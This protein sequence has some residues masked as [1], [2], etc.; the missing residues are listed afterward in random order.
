MPSQSNKSDAVTA[1]SIST[2]EIFSNLSIDDRRTVASLMRARTYEAGEYVIS[3][4]HESSEVY[5]LI[6]GQVKACAFSEN[7]KQIYFEDLTAGMM[8]GEFAA[9]D[10]GP[11][12]NDC[13][14]MQESRLC[15]LSREKFLHIIHN[16]P[17]VLES[18]LQRLVRLIRYQMQRVYEFSSCS[19]NQRIRFEILRL[20][21]ETA[22]T[23]STIVIERPPTHSDIAA[24]ISTHREAVTR[25]L[26][27]LESLGVITWRRGNYCVHDRAKLAELATS[28]GTH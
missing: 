12:S 20:V 26:K 11:R 4:S 7:G 10:Q 18:V 6:S 21:S 8:F 3:N 14:V 24:R 19:V 5:F 1:T 25:E 22:S 9:I 15:V 28:N 16:Y 23:D 2:F 17:A 27:N 13:I